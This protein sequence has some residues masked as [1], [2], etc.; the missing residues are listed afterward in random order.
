MIQQRAMND[1]MP[2]AAFGVTVGT[3][4]II[5]PPGGGAAMRR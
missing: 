3:I 5:G 1:F 4:V 2:F